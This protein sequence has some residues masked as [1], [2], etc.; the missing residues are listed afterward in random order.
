M[1]TNLDGTV[2]EKVN[3]LEVKL[4]PLSKEELE[5]R[6]LDRAI[7]RGWKQKDDS[8]P[9]AGIFG[10]AKDDDDRVMQMNKI[11]DA[12]KADI[13]E[14]ANKALEVKAKAIVE[15]VLQQMR[16]KFEEADEAMKTAIADRVKSALEALPE[17]RLRTKSSPFD[18]EW[19]EKSPGSGES[20]TSI[21]LPR[22]K[23]HLDASTITGAPEEAMSAYYALTAGNPMREYITVQQIS[24]GTLHV[25]IVASIPF[26]A[27][28]AIPTSGA[29]AQTAGD[30]ALSSV[31]AEL[32]NYIANSFLSVPAVQDIPQLREAIA[33]EMLM[34]WGTTQ[35]E[36]CFNAVHSK[37]KKTVTGQAAKLP[38][39]A[40]ITAKLQ[41][42]IGAIEPQYLVG[43]SW[44]IG[45]ALH[46]RIMAGTLGSG[47]GY[48]FDPALGV[49][50]IEGYPVR[51]NGHFEAGSTADDVSGAFGNFRRGVVLVEHSIVTIADEY[52]QTRPGS[53]TFHGNGRCAAVV[54]D[55]NAVTRLETEA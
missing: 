43:A 49:R 34:G 1:R 19:K 26:R 5:Q 8:N 27:V 47:A 31:T 44:Q 46:A 55:A 39:T 42:M 36:V 45:Q 20:Y 13:A 18:L 11:A 35:G 32:A 33:E 10:K 21:D 3:G 30:G 51:L 9:F 7:A 50:T 4:S 2:L 17:R 12:V 15:D 25:P 23:Y 52:M 48:D 29:I 6:E 14:A 24:S 40:N 22:T 54:R 28:N 16:G 37:A 41:E 38:T 53:I